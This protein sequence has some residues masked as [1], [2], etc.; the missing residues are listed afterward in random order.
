MSQKID[1]AFA[2]LPRRLNYVGL[3]LPDLSIVRKTDD[4]AVL[5]QFGFVQMRGSCPHVNGSGNSSLSN[6]VRVQRSDIIEN[7][8]PRR[9]F[10]L[11][12]TA[13]QSVVPLFPLKT[14]TG[15]ATAISANIV[16]VAQKEQAF[17]MYRQL[18]EV[19][20]HPPSRIDSAFEIASDPLPVPLVPGDYVN[21]VTTAVGRVFPDILPARTRIID[22]MPHVCMEEKSAE[23]IISVIAAV[24]SSPEHYGGE[25]VCGGRPRLKAACFR[26]KLPLSAEA[27]KMLVSEEWG[28]RMAFS[29]QPYAEECPIKLLVD[30]SKWNHRG[31]KSKLFT[32]WHCLS[33]RLYQ[34]VSIYRSLRFCVG[35][36]DDYLNILIHWD[37]SRVTDEMYSGFGVFVYLM[38]IPMRGDISTAAAD[39]AEFLSQS[40]FI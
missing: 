31:A 8:L 2:P 3:G 15:D 40:P 28:I 6:D 11:V 32:T 21:V 36:G 23:R 14:E 38:S 9:R 29:S 19:A 25:C 13:G 27:E 33:W 7:V 5:E 34:F 12:S 20:P 16:D 26:G 35:D 17:Y 22:S 37:G 30:D 1:A 4:V 24:D 10:E 39:A 18:Q